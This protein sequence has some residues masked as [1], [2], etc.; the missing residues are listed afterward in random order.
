MTDLVRTFCQDGRDFIRQCVLELS[1][2]PFP[3]YTGPKL[4]RVQEEKKRRRLQKLMTEETTAAAAA[5]TPSTESLPPRR[6]VSHFVMNLPDSAIQFLDAFRGLLAD[7]T[8]NFSTLYKTMPMI[9][10]HCFTRELERDRAERD[11]RMVRHPFVPF[12]RRSWTRSGSKKSWVT[13]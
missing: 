13:P 2:N 12:A 8:R 7:G 5:H 9:H 1:D 4:S 10:C 3:P 11:I 6:Y